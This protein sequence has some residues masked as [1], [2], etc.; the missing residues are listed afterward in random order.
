MILVVSGTNRPGS[1]TAKVAQYIKQV[2]DQKGAANSLLDL[3]NLDWAQI[4]PNM[5]DPNKHP[6]SLRS[7]QDEIIIPSQ[8]WIIVSPEYNG[9]F[10]GAVKMWI[11]AISTYRYKDT[12]EGRKTLLVGVASG[13]A[14][15]LRGMEH[16]TGFFNYLKMHVYPTKLPISQISKVWS[17]DSPDTETDKSL[18]GLIDE[19]INY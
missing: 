19:F 1:K 4:V 17:D 8:K 12:F 11:D 6:Q 18:R 2:L 15:N 7:L 13:R 16:I 10:S 9:S 5:Y 14:G 3:E